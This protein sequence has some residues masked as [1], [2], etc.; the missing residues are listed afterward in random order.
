MIRSRRVVTSAK[1]FV[2]NTDAFARA[3]TDVL[4]D[5]GPLVS[6]LDRA[7]SAHIRAREA[8]AACRG[9]VYTTWAALTEAAHLLGRADKRAALLDMIREGAL[10][11]ASLDESDFGSFAW[12][13]A[14]YGERN[15]DLADLSLLVAAERFGIKTLLTFDRDFFVYRTRRGKALHCPIL[16]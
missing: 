15:P 1:L 8:F 4:I 2:R 5:A 6:F 13:H 7:D 11:I 12:F 14:K 10:H 9:R 16:D 3:M